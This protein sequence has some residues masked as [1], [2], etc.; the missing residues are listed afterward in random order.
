MNITSIT[1]K[2]QITIPKRIRQKLN[3]QPKDQL[4]FVQRGDEIILKPIRD[5]LS[6]RG[7][8]QDVRG[9]SFEEIR[10]KTKK[11]IT[12]KRVEEQ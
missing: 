5:I 10:E 2:G 6:M 8:V 11:A 1:Q 12:S 7:S 4:V 9:E 3:L